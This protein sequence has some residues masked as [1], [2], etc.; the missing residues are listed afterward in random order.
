[1]INTNVIPIHKK[2]FLIFSTTKNGNVTKISNEKA[3]INNPLN[4]INT[5]I[6]TTKEQLHH[7]Q[8]YQV[9]QSQPNHYATM[10]ERHTEIRWENTYHPNE[11]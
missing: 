1:M 3:H 4:E 8:F 7:S 6:Q 11:R 2:Y 10:F 9:T 5:L